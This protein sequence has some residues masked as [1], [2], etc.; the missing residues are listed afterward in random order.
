M[1]DTFALFDDGSTGQI[2]MAFHNPEDLPIKLVP[3]N[4]PNRQIIESAESGFYAALQVMRDMSYFT[5]TYCISYQFRENEPTSY[6]RGRSAG[7]AFCL[8]FAQ[9]I[10]HRESGSELP[11]TIAAT[12]VV[13]DGTAMAEVKRVDA[14]VVKLQG[15]MAC[16]REGDKIFYP[17]ENEED[18]GSEIREESV[19]RNIELIS[20]STVEQAIRKL[21]EKF[22]LEAYP[23][24]IEGLEPLSTPGLYHLDRLFWGRRKRVPI[25]IVNKG[26]VDLEAKI[27]PD[28]SVAGC[29]SLSITTPLQAGKVQ[30]TEIDIPH[31]NPFLFYLRNLHKIVFKKKGRLSLRFHIPEVE[32]YDLEK[33]ILF[34]VRFI[35]LWSIALVLLIISGYIVSS[36]PEPPTPPEISMPQLMKDLEQGRYLEVKKEINNYLNRSHVRDESIMKLYHQLTKR[37]HL[38]LNFRY[39]S[40][41]R[42]ADR[43]EQ[44]TTL[45]SSGNIV[46]RS[47]D[48]YGLDFIPEDDCFLYIYQLDPTQNFTQLF[49]DPKIALRQDPLRAGKTYQIPAGDNR[50][51][52]DQNAGRENLY[53]VASRW[54]SRDLEALFDQFKNASGQ[55]EKDAYCKRLIERIK[56][57]HHA[58]SAGVEGCFYKE[59]AFQ[60]E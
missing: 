33:V 50:F 57:R 11:Y 7:L 21:F 10:Y 22:V 53:F 3:I 60:H 4:I 45:S 24:E 9:E 38:K 1:M 46:L 16:L 42:E 49:P 20:V 52:L 2:V 15:A 5:E 47:G 27:N 36:W 37:L 35:N 26:P 43:P 34:N 51:I 44:S 39:L 25:R 41:E 28:K 32:P 55:K 54:P 56:A 19:R 23:L 31:Q 58:R 40:S 48:S 29:V 30:E 13:S 18:I 59:Y 17:S 14:L 12:G 6:T 8:K